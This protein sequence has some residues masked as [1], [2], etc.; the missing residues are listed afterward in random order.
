MPASATVRV[1]QIVGNGWVRLMKSVR[2]RSVVVTLGPRLPVYPHHRHYQIVST[3]PFCANNQ[4]RL[5]RWVL[6]GLLLTFSLVSTTSNPA[7]LNIAAIAAASFAGLRSG[8][9]L[10]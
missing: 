4:Y 9:T 10:L 1:V 8:L 6:A 2:V 3:S 7:F 5:E